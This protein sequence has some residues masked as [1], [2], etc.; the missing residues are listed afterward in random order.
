MPI[1]DK[2]GIVEC[3]SNVISANKFDC[4]SLKNLNE[5]EKAVFLRSLA[6][7]SLASFVLGIRDRHQDN[8]LVKDGHI[9]FHIDFGHLWNQGP[10][11]D[12]PRI[13]VPMR[14]KA[15]LSQSEWDTFQNMCE[16]GFA[17][18]LKHRFLIRD[19]CMLLFAP[20]TQPNP[21]IIDD[22]ISG[23]NSLMVHLPENAALQ[24]FTKVLTRSLANHH[25][26][27][28][29][30]NFVHGLG[31]KEEPQDNRSRTL[32]HYPASLTQTTGPSEK[33]NVFRTKTVTA[34]QDSPP[35]LFRT[36]TNSSLVES[37]NRAKTNSTNS[38]SESP[39]SLTRTKTISKM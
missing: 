11:I 14:I 17:I 25:V 3:V 9:F 32:S 37:P 30:K 15:N 10:L 27:R 39:S 31:K 18:L 20:I 4:S 12:A 1:H 26:R 28:K 38:N 6:G 35:A 19:I 16:V 8:M 7:S 33:S 5:E 36:K 24:A 13:A 21:S 34:P 23:N 22:F 2:F 29:M